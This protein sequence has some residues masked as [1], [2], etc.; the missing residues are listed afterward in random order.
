VQFAPRALAQVVE[1]FLD[2]YLRTNDGCDGVY[3]GDLEVADESFGVGDAK[4][5]SRSSCPAPPSCRVSRTSVDSFLPSR[6]VVVHLSPMMRSFKEP[7]P[8]GRTARFCIRSV[9]LR[10]STSPNSTR[11]S[12]DVAASQRLCCQAPEPDEICW[13]GP[14]SVTFHHLYRFL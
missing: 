9:L 8:A 6:P 7:G 14:V 11:A 13:P 4:T 10:V 1:A 5:R 3:D 2:G 12:T